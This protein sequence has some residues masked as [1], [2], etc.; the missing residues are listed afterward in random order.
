MADLKLKKEKTGR[1]K[2]RHSRFNKQL[3]AKFF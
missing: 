2:R 3:K 1:D